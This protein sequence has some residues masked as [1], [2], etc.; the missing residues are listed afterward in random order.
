MAWFDRPQKHSAEQ[1][2]S[3]VETAAKSFVAELE[4]P[5]LAPPGKL[6]PSPILTSH[7]CNS[8]A[9]YR[10]VATEVGLDVADLAV[11]EFALFLREKDIPVFAHSA[12]VKYMDELVQKD[13]PSGLGWHWCAVREKDAEVKM[14]W[15]RP[16]R[17][18]ESGML[19]I[20]RLRQLY[21]TGYG[22]LA[23]QQG[24]SPQQPKLTPSSD[25]YESHNFSRLR[26]AKEN[27]LNV[28]DFRHILSPTYTRTIPLHALHKIA[29]I[30]RE[31]PGKVVFLVTE[32]TTT[33]HE[34]IPRPDPFLMAVI[35]NLGVAH[36]KGRFIIDV[37][38]EP[39]FGLAEML[40][41][42]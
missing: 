14:S 39:G 21:A 15:G 38:D 40:A 4:R 23:T 13:N 28:S 7:T 32:Y 2:A 35:P 3:N 19:D 18:D 25:F 17:R 27:G 26:Q 36:G 24:F 20:A 42:S 41:P 1:L 22:D 12:V 10:K 33:A 31:F 37:W 11:E 30:E 5:A 8:I 6:K 29:L 34:Y 9:E 16:S